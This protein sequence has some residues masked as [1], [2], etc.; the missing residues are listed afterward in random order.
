MSDSSLPVKYLFNAPKKPPRPPL[1]LIVILMGAIVFLGVHVL[2]ET[3]N[4]ILSTQNQ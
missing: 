1:V 4:T 3:T 2:L